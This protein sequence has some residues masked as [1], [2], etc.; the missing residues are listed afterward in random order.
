MTK[1][2]RGEERAAGSPK[3]S[4]SEQQGP[5]LQASVK[6]KK[7]GTNRTH[8]AQEVL[9]HFE[10]NF[11]YTRGGKRKLWKEGSCSVIL[12]KGRELAK[13]MKA[14]TTW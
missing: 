10:I 14:E 3:H 4:T 7:E 5:S 13:N 8:I 2:G 6:K 9:K 11:V 1:R 12:T